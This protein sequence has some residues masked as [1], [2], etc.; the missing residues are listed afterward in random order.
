MKPI[1]FESTETEFISNGIGR[2]AD[3]ITCTVLEERNGQ[4]ELEMQ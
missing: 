3:A 4:Y 2:L 1:L